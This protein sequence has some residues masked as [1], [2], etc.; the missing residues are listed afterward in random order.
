M[1]ELDEERRN[2]ITAYIQGLLEVSE[3]DWNLAT[4]AGRWHMELV[5]QPSGKQ[6][7]ATFQGLEDV[8]V[9]RTGN[10]YLEE[11][12][13]VSDMLESLLLSYLSSGGGSENEGR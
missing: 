7:R 4:G 9:Q 13:E 3:V 12:T 11:G 6:Y 8:T 2:E 1:A 5:H 10:R